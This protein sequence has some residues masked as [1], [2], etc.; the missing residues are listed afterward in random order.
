MPLQH[1]YRPKSFDEFFGN[2]IVIEA[3]SLLLKREPG[4]QPKAYIITGPTGIGKTTIA[5][6]IKDM[7]GC[8]DMD[9]EEIDASSDRGIDRIRKLKEGLGYSGLSGSGRKVVLLDEVHGI[10]GP[11]QEALLKTL[12]DPPGNA[13]LILCTTEPFPLKDTTKRRCHIINLSP[14]TPDEMREYIKA[15]LE[16]EGFD[17]KDYPNSVIEKI[18]TVSQGL[19]GVAAKVL[20]SI[21]DMDEESKILY[22]IENTTYSE[23]AVF[24]IVKHLIDLHSGNHQRWLSIKNILA[25]FDGDAEGLRRQILDYL[26]KVIL[27]SENIIKAAALIHIADFFTDNF[28]SSG[29]TGLIIAC[30][31]AIFDFSEPDGVPCTVSNFLEPD[32]IPF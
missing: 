16:A 1:D 5:Y 14:L 21:I 22:V 3:L 7:A 19:P 31:C 15:I 10:T 12:E 13:V 4:K 26:G 27:G 2:S 30:H 11:A 32:D 23:V 8:S 6:I 9:F 18:A 24:N 29:K 25:K 20:D 17:L 28:F